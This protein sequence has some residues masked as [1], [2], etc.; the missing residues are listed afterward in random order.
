MAQDSVCAE[1]DA[2]RPSLAHSP[3]GLH[4]LKGK[5]LKGELMTSRAYVT[6][7][8]RDQECGFEEIP[9]GQT[10]PHRWRMYPTP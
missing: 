3:S 10:H 6:K 7:F 4:S 5:G 9:G 8:L 1:A 2:K